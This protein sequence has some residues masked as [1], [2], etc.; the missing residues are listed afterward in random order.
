MARIEIVDVTDE[1]AFGQVP[2]C[3]DSSFD[4]RTCDYWE[5]ADRGS[6][7][8]RPGWL[9]T[10]S[11]SGAGSSAGGSSAGS[12]GDPFAPPPKPSVNPFVPA[13]SAP[14]RN[15]FLYEPAEVADNPIAPHRPKRPTF[16]A[17]APRKLKLLGRGL[18]IFGSYARLLLVDGESVA[19]CQFGPL[20]AYPRALRLRELYPQLPDAPLPA[21]VTC[22]ATT[23]SARRS[24]YALRLVG[25]GCDELG[26]RGFAAVEAYP[27]VDARE[28]VTPAARPEFWIR[29]GFLLAVDDERY[30]VMLREPSRPRAPPPPPPPA[31]PPRS[32]GERGR[33][34][35]VGLR[36]CG[37]HSPSRRHG[38]AHR[39]DALAQRHGGSIRSTD[40]PDAAE[41]AAGPGG[42]QPDRGIGR[43]RGPGPRQRGPPRVFRRHRGGRRRRDNGPQLGPRVHRPASSGGPDGRLLL[44]LARP[45]RPGC[46]LS[47]RRRGVGPAG[48]DCRPDRR[49][50]DM[51]RRSDRIH[52][53]DLGQLARI[54]AGSGPAAS[55]P[56][57]DGRDSVRVASGG[58]A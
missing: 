14:A 45:V 28:D 58:G 26:A 5:D 55:G 37:R 22:I 46:L 40:R 54:G 32:P 10:G 13:L 19:F 44:E 20:S 17:D 6:R 57:A 23:A 36:G 56:P 42:R 15:P 9:P 18:G 48:D 47:S 51:Q 52:R 35:G 2:P 34:R 8:A 31:L 53:A 4:H 16:E 21:V 7:A 49:C 24:G 29:A 30:P 27:E 11:I 39:R 38:R 41:Q 1:V 25:S 12:A 33:G 3:A 50:R 43:H